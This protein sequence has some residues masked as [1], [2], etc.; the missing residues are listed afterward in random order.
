M[1]VLGDIREQ[2]TKR[3]EE[4]QPAFDE[5]RE[6]EAALAT[7]D[8]ARASDAQFAGPA[9]ASRPRARRASSGSS[10]KGSGSSRPKTLTGGARA[11]EALALVSATPG[12]KVADL[13]KEMAVDTSYLYRVLPALERAGKV[14][15][16]DKGYVP[17][18]S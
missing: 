18:D 9:S 8:P 17:A 14:K 15:K 5:Y 11:A 10:R 4:L 1:S 7:L 6:V 2:L 12:I 3:L 16:I 13:A